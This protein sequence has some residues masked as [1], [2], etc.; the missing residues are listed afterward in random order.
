[1]EQTVRIAPMR[2]YNSSNNTRKCKKCNNHL[3]LS[4]FSKRI[5]LPSSSTK[6]PDKK[7]PTLYY[8]ELCKNCSLK[9][10]NNSK[11]CSPESRKINHRKDPRKVMLSHARARAIKNNLDF[12]IDYADII[13]PE[14]C[15]FLNIPIFVSSKKVGPNSPTIDRI[16]CDKGY[17]KGNVIVISHKANVAKSN[18]TLQELELLI[19]NLKRVL[20]KEEELLES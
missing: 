17:T 19:K 8:R 18:L 12:N 20:Y 4:L 7:V 11:Y 15:P 14:V 1:M 5:R 6:D 9:T 10:I 16:V 3:D 13:V 2:N